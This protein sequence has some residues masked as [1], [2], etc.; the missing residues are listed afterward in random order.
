[1]QDVELP[2][3]VVHVCLLSCLG[4]RSRDSAF[5]SV[6]ASILRAKHVQAHD[7]RSS[8]NAPKPLIL[9]GIS[10]KITLQE[11]D[12]GFCSVLRPCH[13][14]PI[15]AFGTHPP[16]RVKPNCSSQKSKST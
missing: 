13:C 14:L 7:A 15:S 11:Q 1:M 9:H 10:D 2:Y 3:T 5:D 4:S 16:R 12:N 8:T 6:F